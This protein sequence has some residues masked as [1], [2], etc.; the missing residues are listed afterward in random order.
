MNIRVLAVASLLPLAAVLLASTAVAG[1][2]GPVS[3]AQLRGVN[4]VSSCAFSHRAADDPIVFFGKPGASH[5]HSFVGN[6][7]TNASSTLY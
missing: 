1:S 5:D 4:F 2:D 3:R 6:T 7:G